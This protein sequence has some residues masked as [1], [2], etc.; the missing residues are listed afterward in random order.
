MPRAIRRTAPAIAF[1]VLSLLTVPA[2][3]QRVPARPRPSRCA[4][5]LRDAHGLCPGRGVPVTTVPTIRLHAHPPGSALTVIPSRPREGE[6]PA[7]ELPAEAR[8][9]VATWFRARSAGRQAIEARYQSVHALE[10]ERERAAAADRPA[11]E[12]RM[13]DARAALDSLQRSEQLRLRAL[14]EAAIPPLARAC[15]ACGPRA[16]LALAELTLDRASERADADQPLDLTEPLRYGRLAVERAPAGTV[17]GFYA[18]TFM[19]WL[20]DESGDLD[21]SLASLRAAAEASSAPGVSVS[22]ARVVWYQ[23]AR[24][25]F[26]RGSLAEARAICDRALT[27]MGP[28][29][30]P[31]SELLLLTAQIDQGRGALASLLFLLP[32]VAAAGVHPITD[33]VWAIAARA[34]THERPRRALVEVMSR[35]IALRLLL[36]AAADVEIPEI[37]VELLDDALAIPP[38]IGALI[39]VPDSVAV[40]LAS[41]ARERRDARRAEIASAPPDDPA[42]WATRVIAP[43]ARVD[44]GASSE[45]TVRVGMRLESLPDGTATARIASLPTSSA[46]SAARE[47]LRRCVEAHVHPPRGPRV[48][49]VVLAEVEFRRGD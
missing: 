47:A 1:A 22:D 3:A 14:R 48:R 35:D 19:G 32:R 2:I 30:S 6:P 42:R 5:A 13:L 41:T 39:G 34:I 15:S 7:D 44:L 49:G 31:P 12:R 20:L 28:R 27:S 18:H 43:C 17:S 46:S 36:R 40:S 16:A 21:G 8:V 45:P 11:I 38:G 33:E 24:S 4:D 10:A 29:E 25:L 23:L 9:P 37:A 26:D